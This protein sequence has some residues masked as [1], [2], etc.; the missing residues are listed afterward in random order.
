[1]NPPSGVMC[2]SKYLHCPVLKWLITI[3]FYLISLK[4]YLYVLTICE[5]SISLVHFTGQSESFV[6][7]G[8]AK[9]LILAPRSFAS[10]FIHIYR[11]VNDGKAL[12]LVHKVFIYYFET[13]S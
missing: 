6:A 7:V 13:S 4:V 8:T 12:E 3:K 9:D 5:I 1:M 2:L 11:F 10:C